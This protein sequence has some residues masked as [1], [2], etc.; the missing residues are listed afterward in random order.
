[1]PFIKEH[2]RQYD[3][4]VFGATGYTGKWTAEYIATNLPTDLKWAV[5][6]RSESKL[7]AVVD[8]CKL[9]N[10]DR[11][12]P[13]IEI[14]SLDDEQLSVLA[15]KT[16]VLISTVGPYSLYGEHAFKACAETG[17]HYVDVTGETPWVHKMIMKYEKTAKASGAIMFPQ[18]GIES[19]PADLCTWALAQAIR[20]ELG[21]P[22]KDVTISL[23]TIAS[24]PSGG[25]LSTVLSLF[26]VFSLKELVA[27]NSPYAQSPI[28]HAEPTR[29]KVS[30]LQKVFGV[31]TIPNLGLLTTSAMGSTD[32]PVVERTWGLLSETP[33]RKD[34]FYGP[35]FVWAEYS[36]ARN[37]L[38]GAIIHIVLFVSGL[39]LAFVPPFRTVVKRYIYQPGE[40][41]KKEDTTKEEL[42]FRGV[43]TPDSEKFAGKQAYVRAWHHGGMYYLTGVFL[44]EIAA[45]IL[46][47]DLK[48]DGG[49]YT[50]ALLGQGL[51]DRIG[52]AGFNM[53]VKII[54][55]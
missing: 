37:W 40:G 50:P 23:H 20:T 15:K 28:P 18:S 6:G 54:D 17:T 27:S 45:T 11:I 42:E 36:K 25:T 7:Q 51:I 47:D 41:A 3:V 48:L 30:L 13:G 19:A 38:H 24:T 34:Q 12:L 14:A 21:V 2:T 31:R 1:M 4:I 9:L 52:K 33:S 10:P 39:L 46:Q 32:I 43:A 29:P 35:N 22:T 44:A 5:A 53:E 16:C 26:D 55:A 8:E 49:I